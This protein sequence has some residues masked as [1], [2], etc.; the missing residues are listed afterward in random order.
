VHPLEVSPNVHCGFK[1]EIRSSTR[2][3]L[4]EIL[5]YRVDDSKLNCIP[6]TMSDLIEFFHQNI[7]KLKADGD[8]GFEG[9]MAAILGN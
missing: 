2:A 8:D 4:W 9:L 5:G 7:R 6:P 1:E 3:L